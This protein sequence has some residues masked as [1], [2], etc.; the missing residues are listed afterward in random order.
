MITK[1][2]RGGAAPIPAGTSSYQQKFPSLTPP[3]PQAEPA[4][5]IPQSDS[6][7]PVRVTVLFEKGGKVSAELFTV[8]ESGAPLIERAVR[9]AVSD[10]A[11][12]GSPGRPGARLICCDV[13]KKDPDYF[14]G[15]FNYEVG[16]VSAL[17]NVIGWFNTYAMQK[18]SAPLVQYHLKTRGYFK[19]SGYTFR[20]FDEFKKSLVGTN[21]KDFDP[22]AEAHIEW[23]AANSKTPFE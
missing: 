9:T 17:Q 7:K 18:L 3:V 20:L 12:K 16:E 13:N 21:A 19:K 11:A 1:I 22:I 5:L 2:E 6:D 23:C 8:P 10:I 14:G 4:P 15:E